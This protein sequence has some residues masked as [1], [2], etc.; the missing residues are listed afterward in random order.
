MPFGLLHTILAC[1]SL[2]PYTIA[3]LG[4]NSTGLLH[5]CIMRN[6]NGIQNLVKVLTS[7]AFTSYFLQA[8]QTRPVEATQLA[9]SR[10]PSPLWERRNT[11]WASFSRYKIYPKCSKGVNVNILQANWYKAEQYCRFHGM[12]LAR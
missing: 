2:L 9:G 3:T 4:T 7:M 11:T 5:Q 12:H 8:A 6:E 10:C 1:N